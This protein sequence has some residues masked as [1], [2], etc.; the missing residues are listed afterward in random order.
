MTSPC[1]AKINFIQG[2]N[3]FMRSKIIYITPLKALNKVNE[4]LL[5]E[6]QNFLDTCESLIIKLIRA[7]P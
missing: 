3:G 6:L 5:G 1:Y 7:F 4:L 2:K